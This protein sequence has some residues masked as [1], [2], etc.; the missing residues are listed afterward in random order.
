[1]GTAC[2]ADCWKSGA[3]RVLSQPVRSPSALRV[4]NLDLDKGRAWPWSGNPKRE[5]DAPESRPGWSVR[6][7]ATSAC[8]GRTWPPPGRDRRRNLL[9]RCGLMR[10]ILGAV[11]RPFV[12]DAVLEPFSR[13]RIHSRARTLEGRGTASGW[14]LAESRLWEARVSR[15]HSGARGSGMRSQGQALDPELFLATNPPSCRCFPTR[16][17]WRSSKGGFRPKNK[18]GAGPG[19]ARLVL[20][21][22]AA[23]TELSFYKEPW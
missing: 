13:E 20:A 8:L 14:G 17:S 22:K 11:L 5:N 6:K 1:M 9:R 16:E 3:L 18:N 23:R 21:R 4:V 7:R 15:S 2:I 19:D 12:R 10:R